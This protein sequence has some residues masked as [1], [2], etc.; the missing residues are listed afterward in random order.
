MGDY[1]TYLRESAENRRSIVC[2]GLDPVAAFLPDAVGTAAAG[3]VT[4]FSR[5]FE[6]MERR[7]VIPGAFKPNIGYYAILDRPRKGKFDGSRALAEVLDLI[8]ATFPGVPV[9]LDAKRGDIATSS[10][11]YALEAFSS[12]KCDAVTVSPYMGSDSVGPFLQFNRGVYVLCRTSNPGA[13]DF[14]ELPLSGAALFTHVV[15]KIMEWSEAAPGIGAVVGATSPDELQQAAELVAGMA[16][17][18]LI[19]GVGSQGG[20]GGET[21]SRLLAAGYDPLLARIN[22]SSGITHSWKDR[23]APVNW[24]AV[25][26]DNLERLQ[27]ET[28]ALLW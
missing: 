10:R 18:L 26:V 17:P 12:W 23:G 9:I 4:F 7:A 20:S 27:E 13:V 14:Q 6:E 16:V 1:C 22:S 28:G 5:I 3:I 25:A 24:P 19:P 2:M 15:K 21:V 8:E 11:N